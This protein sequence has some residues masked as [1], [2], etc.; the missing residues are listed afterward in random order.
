MGKKKRARDR[1]SSEA[2]EVLER[3]TVEDTAGVEVIDPESEELEHFSALDP[4]SEENEDVEQNE[5]AQEEEAAI[6]VI[7][8]CKLLSL[9]ILFQKKHE[10]EAEYN[11]VPSWVKNA[12]YIPPQAYLA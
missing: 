11:P 8:F 6:K 3:V 5:G 9:F 4:S 7:R 12:N 2:E 10:A 1:E